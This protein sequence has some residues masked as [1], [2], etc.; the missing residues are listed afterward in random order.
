MSRLFIGQR[1]IDFASDLTKELITDVCGERIVLYQISEVKSKVHQVYDEAIEKVFDGPVEVGC[2]VD[3]GT[4]DVKTG[5]GAHEEVRTLKVYIHLR[6]LLDRKI[7]V[8]TGDYFSYGSRFFEIV[9]RRET[10]LA[11]GQVETTIG[12]ELVG[13]E[14]REGQFRSALLGRLPETTESERLDFVQQRGLEENAEGRT[15]DV[16]ELQ[17]R[18]TLSVPIGGPREV[19]S[20]GSDAGEKSFYS[21]D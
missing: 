7:S 1:E 16:R 12:L 9:A 6:D 2:L 11:F 21:D 15:N 13:R 10:Q 17:R 18:G 5:L 4:H 8:S 20:R 3:W 14:A 19:S